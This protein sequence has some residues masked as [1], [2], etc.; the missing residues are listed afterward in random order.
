MSLKVIIYYIHKK[1]YSTSIN[2]IIIFE[3]IGN[4]EEF[5]K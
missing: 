3:T 5:F 1:N 2:P 4:S